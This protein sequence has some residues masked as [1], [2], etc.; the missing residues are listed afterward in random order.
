M[1]NIIKNRKEN[2][3]KIN[4]ITFFFIDMKKRRTHVSHVGESQC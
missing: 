4:C 1:E 2:V 3:I